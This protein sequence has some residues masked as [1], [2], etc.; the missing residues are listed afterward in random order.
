MLT[1]CVPQLYTEWPH[2]GSGKNQLPAQCFGFHSAGQHLFRWHYLCWRKLRTI[3]RHLIKSHEELKYEKAY[4][5]LTSLKSIRHNKCYPRWRC[6]IYSA[7]QTTQAY[8]AAGSPPDC[9]GQ[10]LFKSAMKV[11]TRSLRTSARFSLDWRSVSGSRPF[12]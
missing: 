12:P 1:P 8:S 7:V 4:N 5:R 3:K 6:M 9:T 2:C 10:L 11:S